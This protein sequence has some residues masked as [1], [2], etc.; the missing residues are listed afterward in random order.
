MIIFDVR[1]E[2]L[3]PFEVTDS[4]GNGVTI[5]PGRYHLKGLDHLVRQA[6][7]GLVT[8]GMDIQIVSE[9]DGETAFTVTAENLAKYIS[10]DDIEVTV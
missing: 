6:A 10:L 7:D 5:P 9:E 3:K 1:C 8:T 2:V 4:A